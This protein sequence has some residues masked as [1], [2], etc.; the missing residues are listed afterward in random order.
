MFINDPPKPQTR[1][2]LKVNLPHHQHQTL[3]AMQSQT[4]LEAPT[5]VSKAL[6]AYFAKL[7]AEAQTGGRN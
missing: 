6:N 4:G 1:K 3:R 5:L 7:A 2:E